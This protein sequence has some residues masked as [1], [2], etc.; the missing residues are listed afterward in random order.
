MVEISELCSKWPT[1]SSR[2]PGLLAQSVAHIS[3]DKQVAGSNPCSEL[4]SFNNPE[5]KYFENNEGKEHTCNQNFLLSC[6]FFL[7]SK[8]KF[9]L[10]Y[11]YFANAVCFELT[12]YQTISTFD[13][14]EK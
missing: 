9:Q 3:F 11:I 6:I 12:I 4:G 7:P 5:R 14:P 1:T 10:N 13:D 2:L 8:H